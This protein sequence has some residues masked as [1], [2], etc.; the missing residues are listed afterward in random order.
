MA[1]F[2]SNMMSEDERAR[3]RLDFE[4]AAEVIEKAQRNK[5]NHLSMQQLIEMSA[6]GGMQFTSG[7]F[8]VNNY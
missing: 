1:S 4:A 2:G 3:E 8:E 6:I 5:D 7:G